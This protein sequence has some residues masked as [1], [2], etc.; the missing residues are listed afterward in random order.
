MET[1]MNTK[2]GMP[3]LGLFLGVLLLAASTTGGQPVLGLGM[4]AVMAIYSA[5]LVVFGGRSETIAVLGGRPADERLAS[6]NILATAVAGTVAIVVAIA[7]FLWSIAH[8]QSGNDF[9]VVAAAAG[10]GYLGAIVWFRWR[11]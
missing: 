8:G 11:G 4:F 1:T 2:W 7:G 10:I 3:A 6:F 9:A 5:I